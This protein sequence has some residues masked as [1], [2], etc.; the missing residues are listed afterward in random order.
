MTIPE[1]KSAFLYAYSK[2]VEFIYFTANRVD[3]ICVE[4]QNDSDLVFKSE[5]K[6]GIYFFLCRNDDKHI[7]FW[8]L[9]EPEPIN[10]NLCELTIPLINTW[11]KYPV[12]LF[13]L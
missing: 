5:Q 1:L 7:K 3:H 9:N 11:L 10:I 13:N 2:E 8:S 12:F 6:L 4:I